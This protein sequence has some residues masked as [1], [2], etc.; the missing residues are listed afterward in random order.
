[1]GVDEALVASAVSL[2][3]PALRFY[4]WRGPWLSVGY[5]QPIDSNRLEACQRAGVGW[6]RRV[7]G[8]RA[9]L[10]GEDLTYAIAAREADLPSG[11]TASYQL[12]AGALLEVFRGLGVEAAVASGRN[13]GQAGDR[14]TFD[15]FAR[16]ARREICVN[17]RKLA[18]S[19]QRRAAGGVLQ[20]GSIRLR[21]DPATAQA[22][23]S[24]TGGGATSLAELGAISDPEAVE[25]ACV[26]AFAKALGAEFEP[27]ELMEWE[28]DWA[29]QRVEAHRRDPGFAPSELPRGASR[30]S[31][32]GR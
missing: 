1:M 23:S 27:A 18:G 16:P 26:E 28:R 4:R 31:M 5:A 19:A 15:C 24:L 12:V 21:S 20:H 14:N 9:V 7:T 3:R 11:L 10:H 22:A 30:A 17:G 8:G 25:K 2:G 29:H 6:V 13:P 32:G